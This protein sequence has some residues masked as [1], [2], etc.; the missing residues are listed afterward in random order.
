M[1]WIIRIISVLCVFT[2]LPAS[3][4]LAAFAATEFSDG[5]Y[6][7]RK[8]DINTAVITDCN[9]T[10]S[11]ITVPGF[12]LGYPVTGIGDYAFLNNGY[13]KSVT[14]PASVSSIG[15]YAFAQC[16]GLERVN[17]PRRCDSIAENAFFN[18]PN[19]TVGCYYGTAAHSFA[20]DH[21]IPCVF[22]DNV[23]LGNA[24]GDRYVSIGDV[25]AVQRHVADLE[26][27]DGIY[28]LASDTNQD[29]TTDI[30]DATVLQMYLA[31]YDVT[32]PIDKPIGI[33]YSKQNDE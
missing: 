4:S 29:G 25:T 21:F 2:L 7:F 33:D 1:K 5:V 19:V 15:S 13:I 24:N 16:E 14:L 10:E 22:L 32:Y 31:L 8:T 18:S 26:R 9:L 20:G 12:V 3:V 28:L 30:R 27:L 11:D 17:I 6:T 23:M